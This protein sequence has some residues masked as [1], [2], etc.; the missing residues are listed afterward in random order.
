MKLRSMNPGILC[1]TNKKNGESEARLNRRETMLITSGTGKMKTSSSY[2]ATSTSVS[3]HLLYSKTT[4]QLSSTPHAQ[5]QPGPSTSV[6]RSTNLGRDSSEVPEIS[7][8][9][10]L[11]YSTIG[12]QHSAQRMISGWRMYCDGLYL[13]SDRWMI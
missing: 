2:P 1:L 12:I 5:T 9:S 7:S 6:L 4:S 10:S 11:P 13:I 3:S 8:R